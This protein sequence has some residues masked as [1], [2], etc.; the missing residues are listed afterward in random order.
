MRHRAVF[1]HESVRLWA[2]DVG[3]LLRR[4][5]QRDVVAGDE[6]SLLLH[7]GA[8]VYGWAAVDGVTRAVVVTWISQGRGGM[9]AWLVFKTILPRCRNQPY[10]VVDAGVWFPW[11]LTAMGFDWDVVSGG[12]RNDPGSFFSSPKRRLERMRQ[13]PGTGHTRSPLQELIRAHAWCGNHTTI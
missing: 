3:H 8:E 2:H 7:D 1:S 13:R 11:P 4:H 6:T 10:V 9:E 12:A 5:V